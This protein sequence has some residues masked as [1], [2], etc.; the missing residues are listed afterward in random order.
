[1]LPSIKIQAAYALSLCLTS[2]SSLL[3]HLFIP[4]ALSAVAWLDE[5]ISRLL[6]S[7]ALCVQEQKTFSLR[8]VECWASGM[9]S[10]CWRV[11]EKKSLRS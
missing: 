11:E 4:L 9:R 5:K 7:G 3:L 10:L 1:M 6:F 8:E 2:T